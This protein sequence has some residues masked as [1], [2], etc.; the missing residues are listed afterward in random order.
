MAYRHEAIIADSDL[1]GWHGQKEST[2]PSYH[3]AKPM[4]ARHYTVEGMLTLVTLCKPYEGQLHLLLSLIA[5]WKGGATY[6]TM[7]TQLLDVSGLQNPIKC[8]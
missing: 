6:Q 8:E 3:T 1:D 7:P 5:C 4:H 2:Q